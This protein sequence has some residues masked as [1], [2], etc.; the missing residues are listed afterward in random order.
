MYEV[1]AKR[2]EKQDENGKGILSF[3]HEA[4]NIPRGND[5][6]YQIMLS[7]SLQ[8]KFSTDF[9]YFIDVFQMET[10]QDVLH[11]KKREKLK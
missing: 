3:P 4:L 2:T 8:I 9:N 11:N 1:L 7:N 10:L 5:I 6:W